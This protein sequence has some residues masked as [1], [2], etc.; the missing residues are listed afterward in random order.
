[1]KILDRYILTTYL[2]TFFSVFIILMLIFILQTIWLFIKELAGKD[3]DV[4]IIFKFLMYYAPKLIPLVLPL[5]ILLSSIMVFGSFAENYEFAAMKST[6]ISLQRAM[7]GLS[8]FIVLLGVVTFFFANN[9]IPWGEYNS[10]NLRKNIAKLKPAMAIAEGQFNEVGTINIKVAKKTGDKGQYLHDVVIHKKAETGSGNYTTIIAKEGELIGQETSDVLKLILKDGNYYDDTPPKKAKERRRRPLTKSSFK[11]YT[12]NTDLSQLNDIDLEEKNVTDKYNMLDISDLTYTIDS[13]K[14]QEIEDYEAFSKN[15][16][17]RFGVKNLNGGIKPKKDSIFTGSNVLD[18][19][20]TYEKLQIVEMAYNSTSSTKQIIYT[21]EKSFKA[22]SSWVNKHVIALHEK[23][24][25]GFACV[26]LFFVGAPLGALIR[27]GGLGLPMVVAILLFLT[28]HFIGIFAKNSAKDGSFNPI[29]ASWFS[30]LIM[31][32]LSVFLTRRATA[33]KGLFE[34]DHIIEP[35]KK[36]LSIKNKN[37][38]SDNDGYSWDFAD[39]NRYKE[40]KLLEII[41]DPTSYNYHPLG[42]IEALQTLERRNLSLDAIRSKGVNIDP[43][44]DISKRLVSKFTLFSKLAFVFYCT[45]VIPLILFFV[46]NN[47]KLPQ[48]ASTTLLISVISFVLFL[49]TYIIQHLK[50]STFY[51]HIN[52]R[53]KSPNVFMFILGLFLYPIVY[54]LTKQKAKEDLS[55]YAVQLLN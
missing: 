33:D 52:Q 17:N 22:K 31:L 6:G 20:S 25:L 19:F 21:N 38:D 34:F 55:R 11:T 43:A 13:L 30:T 12:I 39:F 42:K 3:L 28:Y 29:L 18:I 32:P 15:V 46:F 47:N 40:D 4:I 41:K 49:I 50:I 7:A 5:T 44:F 54:V 37:T 2:K 53:Q 51:K 10:Y 48:L 16:Y 24:S 23:L 27:K 35:I 8:V 26:I 36:L 9:V 14:Q 1:M 45:G